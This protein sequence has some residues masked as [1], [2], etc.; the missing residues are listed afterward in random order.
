MAVRRRYR[1]KANCFV[2]AVQLDLDTGGF[3]YNKWGAEQRCKRGDWI[4]DNDGDTY[5]VDHQVFAKTYRR[6]G[7]GIY[8]K[9]TPVWAEAATESGSVITKE[10]ASN[11]EAGDYLVFNNE[12]GTDAYCMEAAKFE[13]MYEPDE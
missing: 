5:T 1:K 8:I 13:S 6:V 7:P 9:T 11:Y 2:V 3:T 4:I 10:G 12:D